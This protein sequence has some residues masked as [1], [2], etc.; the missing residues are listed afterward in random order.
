[1][2]DSPWLGVWDSSGG[3]SDLV[4]GGAWMQEETERWLR[5]G[6]MATCE[7]DC[8]DLEGMDGWMGFPG[9]IWMDIFIL[10]KR[11][12]RGTGTG[13]RGVLPHPQTS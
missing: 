13:T 8:E 9:T 11:A 3:T 12:P 6:R 2:G 4:G 10:S 5:V 1:V 7:R